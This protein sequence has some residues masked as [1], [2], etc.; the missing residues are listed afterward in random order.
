MEKTDKNLHAL[1]RALQITLKAN[2]GISI[3]QA[4][5]KKCLQEAQEALSEEAR[6][7]SPEGNE[8][9]GDPD[10]HTFEVFY[11]S[12][13]TEAFLGMRSKMGT[14]LALPEVMRTYGE[15][16]E[17]LEMHAKVTERNLYGL[18]SY[19]LLPDTLFERYG[20]KLASSFQ[21]TYEDVD[22]RAVDRAAV[23]VRMPAHT[24]DAFLDTWLNRDEALYRAL[25]DW[26]RDTFRC[27]F[28]RHPRQDQLAWLKE[29]LA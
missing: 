17:V 8:A 22:K 29:M 27:A 16:A 20:M 2:I 10:I 18:P 7:A 26:V 23:K 11:N 15:G 12:G 28:A 24:W 6:N 4:N 19:Y 9:T 21:S 3:S 25:S 5:L 14:L 1:A 13:A